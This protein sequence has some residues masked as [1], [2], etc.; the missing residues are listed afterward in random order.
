MK[1]FLIKTILSWLA[2]ITAE[3]WKAAVARVIAIAQ[4]ATSDSANKQARFA[5]FMRDFSRDTPDWA[6]NLLRET[7]V[8]YARKKKLIP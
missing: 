6:V 1:E 7:A 4:I 8:A 3:Q 2:G 5:I